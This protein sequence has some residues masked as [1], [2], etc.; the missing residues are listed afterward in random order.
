MPDYYVG[1]FGRLLPAESSPKPDEPDRPEGRISVMSRSLPP[2]IIPSLQF[3][4]APPMPG[5][6]LQRAY[7]PATTQHSELK[8]HGHSEPLP[9]V[10]QLLT[11]NSYPSLPESPHSPQSSV[12]SHSDRQSQFSPYIDGYDRGSLPVPGSNRASFSTPSLRYYTGGE[13]PQF[14]RRSTLSSEDASPGLTQYKTDWPNSHVN[15]SSNTLPQIQRQMPPFHRGQSQTAASTYDPSTAMS[16][17]PPSTNVEQPSTE[18][19]KSTAPPPQAV[20]KVVGER[21]ISNEGMCYVYEDGSY[22]RKEID[23]EPVNANWGITKA[24]KPRKRLAIA[25]VTCR[26]KKISEHMRLPYIAELS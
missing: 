10:S 3:G 15:Y 8:R 24:G 1:P 5:V 4:T 17:V 26:E 18:V 14:S 11:P 20:L 25:C 22:C 13:P 16:Y 6:M 19:E 21:M 9:S 7:S 12:T 2:P 23:G